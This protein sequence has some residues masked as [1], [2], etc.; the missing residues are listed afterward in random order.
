M[1]NRSEK[2]MEQFS[3][4]AVVLMLALSGCASAKEP[5][6]AVQSSPP[7]TM[8]AETPEPEQSEEKGIDSVY[9]SGKEQTICI[10]TPN[11]NNGTGF[12]YD[13][14]YVITNEHVLYDADDFTL[15]DMN[16]REYKG[17]VIFKDPGND[18]AVIRSE[19]LSGS[20]VVFGD[21][22]SLSVGDVLLCIGNPA[23]GEPF[24][25]CT[26]QC[27]ELDEE[28]EQKIDR[29]HRFIHADADII[30][31]YS[32]GPVFNTDGEVIGL[33]YAA[34]VED[35][36]AYEFDHLCLIIPINRVR[37]LIETACAQ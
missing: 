7:E 34:Y 30:S 13:G 9:E 10:F 32:G 25:F 36:S 24:S 27:L 19:D 6:P 5:A 15:Q 2:Y 26:G 4:F 3:R 31:G 35:L 17:T 8:P 12:I 11:G 29:D 28:L 21:S 18:I 22:D 1:Q 33:S 37:E 16:G 20:S 14:Q 23:E